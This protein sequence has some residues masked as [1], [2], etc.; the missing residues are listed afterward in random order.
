MVAGRALV[1]PGLSLH[2]QQGRLAR[3]D[4]SGHLISTREPEPEPGEA[5]E[6][7]SASLGE[8]SPVEGCPTGCSA[9][10]SGVRALLGRQTP[11]PQPL[12]ASCLCRGLCLSVLGGC[13]LC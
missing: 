3:Q 12:L 1:R 4:G 11:K 5:C 9:S 10:L 2:Q 7:T 13:P 6:D 8:E